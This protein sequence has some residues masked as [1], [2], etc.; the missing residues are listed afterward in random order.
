METRA[1]ERTESKSGFSAAEDRTHGGFDLR[2]GGL[3]LLGDA[4]NGSLAA[5]GV[6]LGADFGGDG[7]TRRH[8]NA[9]AAHLGQ[10]GAFAAQQVF[11]FF[12][13]GSFAVS[14]GINAQRA[15][16]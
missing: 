5:I 10:V 9:D 1:P 3:H 14:E 11:Q 8:R 13:A 4:R 6:V 7:E 15:V 2:D 16:L 12:S